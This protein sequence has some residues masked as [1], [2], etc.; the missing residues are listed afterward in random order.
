MSNATVI[1]LIRI[2]VAFFAILVTYVVLVVTYLLTYL[3]T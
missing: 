2:A 1:V 3:L